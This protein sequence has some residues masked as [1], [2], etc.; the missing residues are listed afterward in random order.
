MPLSLADT[1][2]IVKDGPYLVWCNRE[3]N[4]HYYF[5]L[6]L[7]VKSGFVPFIFA[8]PVEKL[9]TIEDARTAVIEH[10]KIVAAEHETY[11]EHGVPPE[12]APLWG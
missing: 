11:L 12:G 3:E 1:L 10:F 2:A 7:R 8:I 5:T 6:G 4:G 9:E